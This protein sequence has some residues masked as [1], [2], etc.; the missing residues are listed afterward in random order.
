MAAE[1]DQPSNPSTSRARDHLA[2]ERTYLAW[3]RTAAAVMA[4]GLAVAT[5]GNLALVT[6]LLAGGVLVAVGAAGVGLGTHRYREVAREIE[7]G[8][9]D[10]RRGQGAVVASSVVL[11]LAVVVALLLVAVGR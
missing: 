1:T 2:N 8:G 4:L 11:V 3:V 7:E 9:F 5:F 10:A 6:S